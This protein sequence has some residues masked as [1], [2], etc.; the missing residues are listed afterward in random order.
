MYIKILAIK[1]PAS[2]DACFRG[3]IV[4]MQRETT[5]W[6]QLLFLLLAFLVPQRVVILC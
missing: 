1:K 5:S 4:D 3:L 6:A 2:V